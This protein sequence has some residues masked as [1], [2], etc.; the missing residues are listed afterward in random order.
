MT[1]PSQSTIKMRVGIFP[2]KPR[3]YVRSKHRFIKEEI[4]KLYKEN[5]IEFSISPKRE[6]LVS[7]KD[8]FTFPRVPLRVFKGVMS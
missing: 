7:I 8:M 6:Q 2:T 1:H 4:Q 5:I 3:Q